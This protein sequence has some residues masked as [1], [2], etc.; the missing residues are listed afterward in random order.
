M[1]GVV[2]SVPR[3]RLCV[4]GVPA[5]VQHRQGQLQAPDSDLT[6]NIQPAVFTA[7]DDDAELRHLPCTQTP[8]LSVVKSSQE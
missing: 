1:V 4:E 8:H 7:A 5:V 3:L 6:Q 2:W